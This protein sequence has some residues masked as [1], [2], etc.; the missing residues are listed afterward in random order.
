MIR[1]TIT[2]KATTKIRKQG[3]TAINPRKDIKWN[4]KKY[5]TDFKKSEGNEEKMKM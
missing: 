3:V 1:Y 5:S 4:H 2:P